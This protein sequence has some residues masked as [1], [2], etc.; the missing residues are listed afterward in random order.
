MQTESRKESAFHPAATSLEKAQL[1]DA[2][3]HRSSLFLSL[4]LCLFVVSFFCYLCF[5]LSF[6]CLLHRLNCFV[7]GIAGLETADRIY[8]KNTSRVRNAAAVNFTWRLFGV[9]LPDSEIALLNITTQYF[10][11]PMLKRVCLSAFECYVDYYINHDQIDYHSLIKCHLLLNEA[12]RS[13]PC[14]W[15]TTL[16]NT[17]T[18]IHTENNCCPDMHCMLNT[19]AYALS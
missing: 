13:V 7:S 2:M 12:S 4:F 17:N 3:K 14:A 5:C 1:A 16:P 18:M 15:F 11:L 9:R 8:N 19:V 6:F 10:V